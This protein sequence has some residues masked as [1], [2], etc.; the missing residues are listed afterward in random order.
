MIRVEN[1][2]LVCHGYGEEGGEMYWGMRREGGE[3]RIPLWM[4]LSAPAPLRI[5][6]SVLA[7]IFADSSVFTC[8]SSCNRV[9]ESFSRSDSCIFFR[10]SAAVAATPRTRVSSRSRAPGG[11]GGGAGGC[12]QIAF[13]YQP[14]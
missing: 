10:L 5:T 11:A 6:S 9:P 1:I 2:S 8:T 12:L 14:C 4:S 7:F 13:T 3:T